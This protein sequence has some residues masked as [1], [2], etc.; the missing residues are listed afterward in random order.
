MLM[1]VVVLSRLVLESAPLQVVVPASQTK[2]TATVRYLTDE[3][4]A[5]IL[6]MPEMDQ[7]KLIDAAEID[8]LLAD[9]KVVL[10]DVREPKEIQD[11]GTIPG[12]VT[13]PFLQL[14]RRIG[15]LPK[16]KLILTACQTGSGR[17]PRAAALLQKHGYAVAGFCGL[18]GYSGRRIHPP[19]RD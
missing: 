6:K 17:G 8:R 12:A 9:G 1:L 18:R 5:E 19:A 3:Q 11:L 4:W 15:E 2:P 16:D 7:S 10:L 14:E 13:I